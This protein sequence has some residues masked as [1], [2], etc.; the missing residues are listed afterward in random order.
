ML[1]SELKTATERGDSDSRGHITSTIKKVNTELNDLETLRA[2][3]QLGDR[4]VRITASRVREL[5]GEFEN[6]IRYLKEGVN[7]D[8]ETNP[9]KLLKDAQEKERTYLALANVRLDNL[10]LAS[11]S[12][13]EEFQEELNALTAQIRQVKLA[14][15][16]IR[17]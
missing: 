4:Y 10:T 1:Q 13:P 17:R 7:L 9:E 12:R 2:E 11:K 15:S 5:F 16:Q 6:S 14:L 8:R 3:H